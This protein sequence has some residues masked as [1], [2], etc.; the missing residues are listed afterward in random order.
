MTSA[1]LGLPADL[2]FDVLP[3][4]MSVHRVHWTTADPLSFSVGRANR[5]DA[6]GG[7]FGVLYTAA[8]IEGAFVET[9]L[10]RHGRLIRRDVVG[11]RSWVRLELTPPQRVAR[12]HGKGLLWHGQD[13]TISTSSDYGTARALSLAL[14]NHARR[15]TASLI[16]RSVTTIGSAT[17]SLIA[18]RGQPSHVWL[19]RLSTRTG[20]PRRAW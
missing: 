9:V 11:Q 7:E 2:R 12:L 8:D 1:A 14:F 3:E 18:C 13:A 17:L 19:A 5:F 6:P 20:Q 10:R 16:A 4:G 15:L